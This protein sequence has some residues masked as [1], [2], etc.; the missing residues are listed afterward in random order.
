M[1][2]V[3][4]TGA[5]ASDLSDVLSQVRK[6]TSADRRRLGEILV[7]GH[8]INH[9]QLAAALKAQSTAERARRRLGMVVADLGFASELAVA[10]ALAD[11][12]GL[13]AIDLARV[14]TD[15]DVVRQLPRPIAERTGVLLLGEHP[16]GGLVVAAADPTNVLALDDVRLYTRAS[17][18]YV[19]VATSTHIR[20]HLARA[21]SLSEGSQMQDLAHGLLPTQAEPD[22]EV[23]T[24]ADAP[25]VRMVNEILSDASRL[26]ASDIHLEPQRDALRVRYRVDGVLREVTTAPAQIGVLLISRIKILAGLDIAQRRVP[27]DGRA[28]ISVD[29]KHVD[30]RVSTLP[31]M[32]GE[33]VVIRLLT[34][35]ESVPDLDRLGFSAEQLTAFR[36]A[37][38]MPQGLILITGPT[39]SGK[40][41][42]LY[43]AIADISTPERNIITLEDPVEVQLAGITQVQVNP[44]AGLT[45]ESGLRSILRQD[46]DIILVGEVRDA[47]T[48]E[49]ALKAA[50]TGHQVFTT[51][52]TSSAVGALTRLVDMGV[53]PFLVASS[54]V[55]SL[56]QRLVRV[57]CR[58][59]REPYVP[60]GDLLARLG[61]TPDHLRS[62]TPIRGTGCHECGGTGY[63]GRTAV[64]E[65]VS[66]DAAMRRVLTATPNETA[67]A[68]QARR[69][70]VQDLHAHALS[71]AAAGETTYEEVLRVATARWS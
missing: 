63:N 22:A 59:C 1:G 71:K 46:P 54:L 28:R 50:I 18:L 51:L 66:V 35:P 2:E 57:P 7:S 17:D 49:L 20:E 68:E 12:L 61:L 55:A 43:A 4:L 15:P 10:T 33:K 23:V 48:A 6:A 65:I 69:N 32:H 45:F 3:T 42:T 34:R 40:T 36:L 5:L 37:M 27:Q 62:A 26:R 29:G 44:K 56:A 30:T 16:A 70:G 14:A 8:L 52:H 11:H 41:N 67:V 38:G 58:T 53:E 9:E 64:Y 24:E 47:Q 21:W 39:G 60:A 25:I 31:S 19:T 13:I